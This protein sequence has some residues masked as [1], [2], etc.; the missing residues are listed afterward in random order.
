MGWSKPA[1]RAEVAV[2][3]RITPTLAPPPA[4]AAPLLLLPELPPEL[5][6]PHAVRASARHELP[7]SRAR[8]VLRI[9]VPFVTARFRA[10]RNRKCCGRQ[11]MNVVGDNIC[12]DGVGQ[13]L[14]GTDSAIRVRHNPAT[15]MS[16]DR[17]SRLNA[18]ILLPTVTKRG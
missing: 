16:P 1:H 10:D 8:V 18:E 2:S 17:D 13:K 4:A 14:S 12:Q 3:G 7:A 11:H 6:F 5:L 9:R 15:V